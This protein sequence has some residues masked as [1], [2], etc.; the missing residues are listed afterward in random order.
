MSNEVGKVRPAGLGLV[1]FLD[2]AGW[3]ASLRGSLMQQMVH[4]S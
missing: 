1:A 3:D 4:T 2:R